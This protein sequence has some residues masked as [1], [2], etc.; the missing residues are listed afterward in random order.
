MSA[1]AA[2]ARSLDGFAPGSSTLLPGPLGLAV[3]PESGLVIVS[4]HGLWT[5][6]QLHAHLRDYH[7]LLGQVR[8]PGGHVR[9]LVNLKDVG[10]QTPEV[11]QV[12]ASGTTHCH[13]DGDRIAMIVPGSLAKMQMRRILGTRFH[14]YF[15]SEVAARLW[16]ASGA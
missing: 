8:K 7:D 2:L 9:V 15:I 13:L 4:G 1:T 10:V 6:S 16:L 3:E 14:E 5:P 11:T 12:L